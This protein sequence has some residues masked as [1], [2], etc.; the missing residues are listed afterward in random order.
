LQY[1][2]VSRVTDA[3]NARSVPAEK[4]YEL[5][6]RIVVLFGELRWFTGK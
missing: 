6:A 5:R 2:A 3:N 4:E 1:Q